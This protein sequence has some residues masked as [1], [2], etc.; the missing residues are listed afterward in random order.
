M[1]LSGCAAAV[2]MGNLAKSEKNLKSKIKQTLCSRYLLI[3]PLA[4][5]PYIKIIRFT[6]ASKIISK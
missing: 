4:A 3:Q 2:G 1:H 5:V 6:T